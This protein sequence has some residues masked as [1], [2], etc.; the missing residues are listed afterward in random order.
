MGAVPRVFEDKIKRA[1]RDAMA[2]D[3]LITQSALIEYLN[4]KFTHSFDFRYIRRLT[5]KVMG[6]AKS[7]IDRALIEP[8]LT[9]LRE[10]HRNFPRVSRQH[11]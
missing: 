5:D 1:I 7:E 6:Q 10:T 11:P 2:S 4:K 8:R 9:A 3:P